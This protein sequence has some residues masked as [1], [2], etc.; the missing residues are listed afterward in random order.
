ME[1]ENS[2]APGYEMCD[3]GRAKPSMGIIEEEHAT[4]G[5]E[6]STIEIIEE[7][8]AR[9]QSRANKVVSMVADHLRHY[10][11]YAAYADSQFAGDKTRACESNLA[12]VVDDMS[13][14]QLPVQ[15]STPQATPLRYWGEQLNRND[16]EAAKL[17]A[18]EEA[19][20]ERARLARFDVAYFREA[21]ASLDKAASKGNGHSLDGS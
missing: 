14:K 21:L 18:A 13:D 16:A 20:K 2:R 4:K 3:K 11:A 1:E 5:Q 15:H 12:I 6:K 19:A 10:A 8:N 17:K 9:Y 7:G